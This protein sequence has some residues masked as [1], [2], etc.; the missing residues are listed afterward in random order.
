MEILFTADCQM[1][2][3]TIHLLGSY[4]HTMKHHSTISSTVYYHMVPQTW[5]HLLHLSGGKVNLS[6]CSWF[7]V[8][9]EWV[10]GHPIIC[11][12]HP[13]NGPSNPPLPWRRHRYSH[14][15]PSYSTVRLSMNAWRVYETV[16]RFRWS[17]QSTQEECRYIHD[18]INITKAV[19][20]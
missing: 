10:K 13:T 8:K 1:R 14:F 3:S 19:G 16:G 12:S 4:H 2:L 17:P 15:D 20:R 5:E 18:L 6:K 7:I 9:W 11:P